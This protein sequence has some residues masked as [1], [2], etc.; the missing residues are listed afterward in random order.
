MRSSHLYK[1]SNLTLRLLLVL[2]V[3]SLGSIANAQK[4]YKSIRGEIIVTGT[5]GLH[6]WKMV[7]DYVSCEASFK[8]DRTGRI[9]SLGDLA[10]GMNV[11]SLKSYDELMDETCYESLQSEKYP[12]INYFA[13]QAKC[14]PVGG[15]QTMVSLKGKMTIAGL[16]RVQ[17]TRAV[18]TYDVASGEIRIVGSTKFN[19]TDYGIEPPSFF[20]SSYTAGDEVNIRFDYSFRE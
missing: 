2:L 12:T 20:M 7:T 5:S 1:F 3:I 14:T 17:E 13:D 18:C 15:G 9:T 11:R 16:T 8:V 6:D 19:M 10:F 4:N